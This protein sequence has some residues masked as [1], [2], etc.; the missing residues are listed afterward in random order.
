MTDRSRDR[1]PGGR[2]RN[3]RP[4]DASGRPLARDAAGVERVPDDLRLSPTETLAEAER[5]LRAG[6]PFAAHEVLESQ[7]K[8]QRDA[9]SAQAPCWQ[10]LAQLAVGLTH[11]QRSNQAG[12]TAL[13]RRAA[14][15]LAPFE[16]TPMHGLPIAELGRWAATLADVL[17]PA[18]ASQAELIAARPPLSA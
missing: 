15:N 9:G 2:A 5:L 14:E 4:R 6:L 10:A 18:G 3:A 12:A 17:E 8:L 13:L 16:A 11:L 1:D 7:W